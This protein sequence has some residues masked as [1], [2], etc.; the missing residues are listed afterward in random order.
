MEPLHR[1]DRAG[2]MFHHAVMDGDD[3]ARADELLGLLARHE[4]VRA[5]TI[6]DRP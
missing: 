1:R 4:R 6:L 2:V 3:L 5:G